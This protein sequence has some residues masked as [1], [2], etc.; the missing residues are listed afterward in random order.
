MPVAM[1]VISLSNFGRVTVTTPRGTATPSK[2][3]SAC[4]RIVHSLLVF[5]L[6]HYVNKNKIINQ[7]DL[8]QL[9]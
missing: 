9:K 7:I 4:T 5:V 3:G 8:K 1:T 6:V 2:I